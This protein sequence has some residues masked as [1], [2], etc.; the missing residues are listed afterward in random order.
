MG[1]MHQQLTAHGSVIVYPSSETML[2]HWINHDSYPKVYPRHAV[3]SII[4]IFIDP[5]LAATQ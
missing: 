5:Y 3:E 4:N 1:E 2:I